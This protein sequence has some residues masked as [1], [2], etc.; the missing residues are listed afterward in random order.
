MTFTYKLARRLAI[1][2][3]LPPHCAMGPALALIVACSAGVP[4]GVDTALTIEDAPLVVNPRS[5]VLESNQVSV[6]KAYA[7]GVPGDSLVTSIEW[8][9]T[10][11]SIGLDGTYSSP[12]TGDYKIVGKRHGPKRTTSDTAIVIVVPPQPTISGV[13][14]APASATVAAGKRQTFNAV[15][16]LSDSTTAAIGV[17]W[18]ATGGYIDAGG[19]YTAGSSAGTYRVI[20][21]AASANVADTVPVIVTPAPVAPPP[22]QQPASGS[23]PSLPSGYA[24]PAGYVD[25]FNASSGVE[26]IFTP[27]YSIAVRNASSYN[28]LGVAAPRNPPSSPSGIG[29]A[30]FPAGFSSGGIAPGIVWS[31]DITS[32]GWNGLY[33]S[34]T[35]Q[36]SSN[37]VSHS[38]A[39]NKVVIANIDNQPML[40]LLAYGADKWVAGVQDIEADPQGGARQLYPNIGTGLVT[41]G[42]WQ[43]VE[44][45]AVANTPG[46]ANGIIR[47]WLTNYGSNGNVVSGP[48][49]VTEYT[50]V[51]WVAS[52]HSTSWNKVSWN[53]I[54]GGTGGPAVPVQQYMWMDQLAVG[55]R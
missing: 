32:N 30:S 35:V 27:M 13:A 4:T 2:R 1:L 33:L 34:F 47:I 52:G 7:S 23:F 3:T 18:T 12:S 41:K 14:V 24:V 29:E 19:V 36:L 26:G 31:K 42:L 25:D 6:F 8:T 50:N 16:W 17:T 44:V 11:G 37:W 53:P 46:Q 21:K 9:A 40:V 39:I 20:A 15:G 55:G 43:R 54:W 38:S 48:T 45:Q 5:L 51:G 22:P 49:K 10:G 28:P